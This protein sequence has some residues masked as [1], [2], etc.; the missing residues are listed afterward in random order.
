MGLFRVR[1]VRLILVTC[2]WNIA[3]EEEDATRY[4]QLSGRQTS[5][6]KK[7]CRKLFEKMS[8]IFLYMYIS[9]INLRNVTVNL[10]EL[11]ILQRRLVEFH[12]T[13]SWCDR[14][15]TEQIMQKYTDTLTYSQMTVN[16]EE[17]DQRSL[18]VWINKGW[19]HPFK[20]LKSHLIQYTYRSPTML[21]YICH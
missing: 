13:T 12:C 17:W 7:Q 18:R 20:K 4:N 21:L 9:C 10:L 15:F 3:E 16:Q 6:S 8:F 11:H 1:F 2:H 14:A 5:N 19:V